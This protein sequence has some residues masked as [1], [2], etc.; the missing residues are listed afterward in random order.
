MR[1]EPSAHSTPQLRPT[2]PEPLPGSRRGRQLDL[3]TSRSRAIARR[4]AG[5]NSEPSLN[6]EYVAVLHTPLLWSMLL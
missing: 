1:C 2:A 3:A 6:S 4:S 5:R